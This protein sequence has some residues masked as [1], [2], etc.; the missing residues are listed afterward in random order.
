MCRWLARCKCKHII[1][2]S[3][4]GMKGKNASSLISELTSLDVK[5]VAYACDIGNLHQLEQTLSRCAKK[6]PP[7]RGVIQ[8]A[9]IIEVR[10]SFQNLLPETILRLTSILERNY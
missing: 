1:V 10:F 2:I 9:I 6:I 5:L 7:V 4:S 3:R 8:S